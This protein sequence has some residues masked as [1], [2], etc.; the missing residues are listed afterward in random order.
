M[1]VAI[2]LLFLVFYP[3][4][5]DFE[6]SFGENVELSGVE[7]DEKT[8]AGVTMLTGVTFP[9]GSKGLHFYYQGSGIDDAL[10]AKIRIPTDQVSSFLANPVFTRGSDSKPEAQ[11]GRDR[12][13][14]QIDRLKNRIDRKMEL[15][16]VKFLGVTFGWEEKEAVVYISW[17]TN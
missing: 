1:A 5:K 10:A 6:F 13:W 2:V 7:F 17:H 14:W 12:T 9:V 4:V 11:A 8:L 15:T 16:N 3:A